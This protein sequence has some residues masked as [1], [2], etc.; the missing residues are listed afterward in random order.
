MRRHAQRHNT[1]SVTNTEAETTRLGRTFVADDDNGR[2]LRGLD[3]A[4][5]ASAVVE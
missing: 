3:V 2:S 1:N 4:A 5:V